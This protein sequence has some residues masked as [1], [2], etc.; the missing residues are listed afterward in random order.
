MDQLKD[1]QQ[2]NVAKFWQARATFDRNK[3]RPAAEAQ[4]SAPL[5]PAKPKSGTATRRNAVYGTGAAIG[6]TMVRGNVIGIGRVPFQGRSVEGSGALAEA[7]LMIRK[8]QS[9]GG[10]GVFE[11]GS[12]DGGEGGR[13]WEGLR[14]GEG[15]GGLGSGKGV[16][17]RCLAE[18]SLR[19]GLKGTG[20]M[21]EESIEEMNERAY[22]TASC[23]EAPARR[24]FKATDPSYDLMQVRTNA[25]VNMTSRMGESLV[26]NDQFW[27]KPQTCTSGPLLLG[28]TGH[29]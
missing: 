5:A 23:M 22:V 20:V 17:A 15:R 13:S 12:E 8:Q 16:L 21:H 7:V 11:G 24:R 6:S 26:G 25:K 18:A 14:A 2:A 29:N 9:G 3:P 28:S 10:L 4:A 19:G 27:R 1:M